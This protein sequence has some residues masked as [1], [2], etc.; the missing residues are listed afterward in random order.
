MR[1]LEPSSKI[2]QRNWISLVE[3]KAIAIEPDSW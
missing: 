2:S 1:I 3:G